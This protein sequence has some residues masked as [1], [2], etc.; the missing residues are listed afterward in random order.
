MRLDSIQA[1]VPTRSALTPAS[2]NMRGLSTTARICRPRAV[3]RKRA[4]RATTTTTVATTTAT[5]LESTP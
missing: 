5:W 1:I 2:C 3:D 4:P